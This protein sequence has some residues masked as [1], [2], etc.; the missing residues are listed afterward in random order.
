M[1]KIF[2]AL[3]IAI[4]LSACTRIETG[5]VGLRVNTSKQ[6]EGSE[7]VEGSWNQTV[8]GDVLTF[9][10][11][12]ISLRV[13]NAT[14]LTAENTR[15]KDLDFTVIYALNRSA[16]SDFWSTA[17]KSYHAN[18]DGDVVL[19][20]NYVTTLANNAAQKV[21]RKY[22]SLKAADA[23]EEIE[24]EIKAVM[25]QEMNNDKYN[26]KIIISSVKVQSILPSD[27]IIESAT[28]LVKAQ[29]DLLRAN[30]QVEIAKKESERMAA[31]AHNADASIAYMQAQAE[32]KI[33]EAVA[34]G[35]VNTIIIPRDFKGI[36]NAK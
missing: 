1:K 32:L 12:D 34:A 5:E 14:P 16:V 36:V 25:E 3:M 7:L 10:V 22:P 33:A 6:I 30:T 15:L 18:S 9:P 20:Y 24:K 11:R 2:A 27:A 29:N 26:G 21:L 17:S 31:L 23:R 4:S 35:K 19:M 8:I 28:A 13:E